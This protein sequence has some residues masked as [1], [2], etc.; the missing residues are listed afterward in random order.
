[1]RD[2]GLGRRLGRVRRSG[3]REG[4]FTLI[5]FL[6]AV[7]ILAPVLGAS[8]I[9]ATQLQ[10]VYGSRLDDAT[11]EEEVRFS[12]DWIAQALRNAGSN[13]YTIGSLTTSCAAAG[14]FTAI[15]ID[16]NGDTVNDDIRLHADINPPD[17]L[18]G[19]A[20]VTCDEDN[21]D[22]TI[23]LDADGMVITREDHSTGGGAEVMTEPVIS[24]LRFTYFDSSGA[25]TTQEGIVAYVR[26]R[27]TGRSPVFSPALGGY[28]ETTLETEVRVRTR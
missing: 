3:R 6:I 7:A 12:I 14:T 9:L 19:G 28:P 17:G 22:L 27:V 25:A 16:P 11:V 10:R 20:A 24:D 23:A 1:M 26:V 21:E 15:D 13:P 8:V 4:G 5:E 18:L 2:D